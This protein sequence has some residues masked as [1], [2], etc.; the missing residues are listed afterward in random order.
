MISLAVISE[1]VNGKY[2]QIAN[3]TALRAAYGMTCMLDGEGDAWVVPVEFPRVLAT[4]FS[5]LLHRVFGV[6]NI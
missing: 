4:F 5:H 6:M 3:D 1:W 2:P